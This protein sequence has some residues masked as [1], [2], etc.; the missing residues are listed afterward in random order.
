M[1]RVGRHINGIFLN[2][3]E[4]LLNKKGDIRYFR[5]KSNAVKFLKS[6]GYTHEGM[7]FLSFEQKE[8]ER[9]K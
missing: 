7:Y 4:Y 6:I 2:G 5:T 3:L 1:I 8:S 9:I